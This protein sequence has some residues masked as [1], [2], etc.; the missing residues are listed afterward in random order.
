MSNKL[1]KQIKN[2]ILL[3]SWRSRCGCLGI[4]V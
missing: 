3:Q 2:K 4:L 1:P